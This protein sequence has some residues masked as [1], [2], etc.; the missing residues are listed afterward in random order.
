MRVSTP[1]YAD[2]LT[3][4]TKPFHP[5]SIHT[6]PVQSRPSQTVPV[7]TIPYQIQR[8]LMN[9]SEKQVKQ[10]LED[11]GWKVLRGGAPDYIALKVNNGQIDI[12]KGVEVKSKSAKLSYE[13]Q[14]YRMIFQKAGIPY[15]VVVTDHSNP[16]HTSP[17]HSSPARTSPNQTT[18]ILSR[19]DHSNPYLPIPAQTKPAHPKPGQN[20]PDQ[21]NPNQILRR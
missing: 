16:H 11:E 19:P 4:R 18:P 2:C 5:R 10:Q 1:F 12:F 9:N 13:Q 17:H 14:L 20:K 7:Q 3:F 15:E 21:A 8:N 6:L